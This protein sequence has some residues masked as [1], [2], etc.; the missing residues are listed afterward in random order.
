MSLI[1]RCPACRTMFKVVPDQ[2]RISEGWVRCGKCEEI[3]DASA[4]MHEAVAPIAD[5]P[6]PEVTLFEGALAAAV[7]TDA[8]KAEKKISKKAASRVP[9]QPVVNEVDLELPASHADTVLEPRVDTELL[10]E[11]SAHAVTGRAEPV[12][13]VEVEHAPA[14]APTAT[15][16]AELSFM[17]GARQPSR[18]HRPLVR[19]T[20][21]VIC[22]LLVLG[23]ALQLLVQERDRLAA[24]EPG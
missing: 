19:A 18:W 24:V 6:A 14:P 2:L 8:R 5:A 9:V 1:T 21:M 23:L 4:H 16:T 12:F 20:L 22:L 15:A 17:R 7:A 11:G 13:S 10:H 3:F